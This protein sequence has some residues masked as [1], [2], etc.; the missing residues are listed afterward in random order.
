RLLAQGL[1]IRRPAGGARCTA[2][3]R[4][5]CDGEQSAPFELSGAPVDTTEVA[6]IKSYKFEPEV[7]RVTRG[8]EITWANE[9]DFPHN[10]HFLTG[11]NATYDLPIGESVTVTLDQ[12]GD[13]YYE[14]SIHPQQMRGKVVVTG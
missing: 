6:A 1:L 5:H 14:C 13:Y 2:R 3:Q 11:S 7:I 10:V 8:S 4:R 12:P 9:D